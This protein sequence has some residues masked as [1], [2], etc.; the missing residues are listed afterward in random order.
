MIGVSHVTSGLTLFDD[1]ERRDHS[2]APRREGSFDFLNRSA[3]PASH[4]VRARLE[5]WFEDYPDDAKNDI[6]GRFRRPDHNHES[7]FF[8]LVLHEVFR[9]LDLAPTVHPTPQSGHGHPDFAIRGRSGSV[10]YV[11]ANVAAQSGRFSE[12]PLEDEQ[13]DAID[14]LAAEEPTTIALYVTTRGK[15]HRSHSRRSIRNEVRRWLE[16]ID[17][18]KDLHPLD[19]RDNPRLEVLRADWKVE[20]LAFGPLSRPSRRLIHVGPMKSGWGDDGDT[21]RSNILEKAKQHG[22]L[23]RPLIIAMNT[24]SGFQD[25]GD[26]LS[27]LFGREQFSWQEDS[28]GNLVTLPH[29]SREPDSVWRNRSGNRYSRLHGVLFFR[30]A[31]PWNMHEVVAHVYINPYVEA[32]IPD[33][34]LQLGSARV[35]DRQMKWEAGAA[36]RRVARPAGGLA[37]RANPAALTAT[38]HPAGDRARAD[39]SQTVCPAG[40]PPSRRDEVREPRSASVAGCEAA[41]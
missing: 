24:Q 35:Q 3:W 37:R 41:G 20:L 5:Q 39:L 22:K 36:T 31:R 14:A 30:G 29:L 18:D 38:L 19:A 16:R 23:E 32:E 28:G 6:R 25:H 34:L 40:P 7:A 4:N 11:E 2:H 9:R 33:E 27:A 12:D 17:P 1:I 21:L 13:L 8:E 10:Y 26:E 15:L